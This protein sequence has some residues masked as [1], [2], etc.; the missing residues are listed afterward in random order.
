MDKAGDPINE[1]FHEACKLKDQARTSRDRLDLYYVAAERFHT[2]GELSEH[3]SQSTEIDQA[4]LRSIVKNGIALK[5][6]DNVGTS[7]IALGLTVVS[8]L[9]G[10][11]QFGHEPRPTLADSLG[12]GWLVSAPWA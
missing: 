9:W 7:A 4:T 6:Q 3:L 10:S 1:V 5:G 2:A 12:L 8:P 11:G